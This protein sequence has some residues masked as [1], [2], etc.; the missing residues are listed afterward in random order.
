MFDRYTKIVLTV[1]AVALSVIAIQDSVGAAR[2]QSVGRI[3]CEIDTD[4]GADADKLAAI[5]R[6]AQTIAD[7]IRLKAICD[8][9]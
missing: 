2:A 3:I 6:T 7:A 1:I 5:T 9:Q 8:G 4:N